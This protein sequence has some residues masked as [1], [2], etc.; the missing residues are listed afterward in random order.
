MKLKNILIIALLGLLFA[1]EP[2]LETYTY[3]QGS[4][5]FSTYVALGNSLTA[6]YADGS[7]YREGQM[8]SYPS[9]LAQQ[10]KTVGGGDFIQPLMEGEYGILPG[11]F[12]LG[13]STDC[14]GT[15]SLGPVPDSGQLDA[16]A[17]IGYTV[18]N[19][20]VP[21]AKTFHLLAPG[22][23]SWA[24]VP[25]G[26]ANPYFARFASSDNATVIGDAMAMNPTFFT[27]WIGSNDVL[28]YA[29]SGGIGDTITGQDTFAFMI[30]TLLN[31]LTS[32]GAKGA[33]ANIPNVTSIPFFTTVPANGLVL[34]DQAQVDGLNAAYQPLGIEFHLGQNYF[35]IADANAPAGLRQAVEGELVCLTIP[36]DS[37]K[38]AGW[39]SQVPIP[40]QYVLSLAELTNVTNAIN[41]YTLS[42]KSLADSYGLALVD[43][44]ALLEEVK[45]GVTYDGDSFSSSFITGNTFSLDGIHLTPKGYVIAANKFIEAINAKYGSTISRLSTT[46]YRANVLP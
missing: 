13:Y 39:G 38:C 7:L 15:T 26:L 17:P 11:K 46:D 40:D 22:Y 27:L 28:G 2:D 42:T 41:G 34:T 8:N 24:G 44:N 45:G 31:N 20:G 14:L 23:G 25:L 1:C 33:I 19:M 37:I 6:G 5:D 32:Q 3:N 9:M 12:K 4:A 43:M 30:N 35:I 10:F 18:N 16:M 36:Q 21:G 29:T